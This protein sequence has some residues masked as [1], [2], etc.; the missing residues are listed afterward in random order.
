MGFAVCHLAGED[1]TCRAEGVGMTHAQRYKSCVI[2]L[3]TD[4]HTDC[5]I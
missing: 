2:G 4:M 1:K 3:H 5:P